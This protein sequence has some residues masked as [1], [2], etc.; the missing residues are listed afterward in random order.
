MS[1]KLA[2]ITPQPEMSRPF[3]QRVKR[4]VKSATPPSAAAIANCEG[5]GPSMIRAEYSVVDIKPLLSKFLAAR[6]GD[7][8]PY[9]HIPSVGANTLYYIHEH[10]AYF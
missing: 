4:K 1:A 6:I 5:L 7:N 9:Y 8:T 10:C 3:D 2:G